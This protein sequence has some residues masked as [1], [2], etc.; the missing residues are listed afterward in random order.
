MDVN[1]REQNIKSIIKLENRIIKCRR[2]PGPLKCISKPA[3]GKGDLVP[4]AIIVFECENTNTRQ[5]EWIVEL[6]N[7]VQKYFNVEAAYHTFMVRCQPKACPLGDAIPCRITN[8]LLGSNDIC[9][10]SN[11]YCSG[12]PIKP[13]D[14]SVVNCLNYLIEELDIFQPRYVLLFGKRVTEFIFRAYGILESIQDRLVFYHEGT[15]YLSI[16][17]DQSFRAEDIKNLAALV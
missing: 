11:Q 4:E 17:N 9:R 10:L 15:T 3:M 5:L 6:R 2:C 1:R 13:T 16:I 7:A 8:P 14:E 12:T